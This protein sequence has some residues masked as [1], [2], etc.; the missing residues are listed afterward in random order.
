MERF[1]VGEKIMKKVKRKLLL[2]AA[3][4]SGSI[5]TACLSP[6]NVYGP[7]PS[8]EIPEAVYGPPSYFDSGENIPEDVYGPP[9]YWEGPEEESE[10]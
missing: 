9:S 7:P 1:S 2:G 4:A 5:F 8:A 10:E 3:L 6:Q